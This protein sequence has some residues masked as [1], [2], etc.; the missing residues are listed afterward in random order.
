MENTEMTNEVVNEVTEEIVKQGFKFPTGAKVAGGTLLI[1]AI[2]YGAYKLVKKCKG[3]KVYAEV[4]T[5]IDDFEG[6]VVGE[7]HE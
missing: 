5:E 4:D 3:K 6:E 1:V 2:G 7:T